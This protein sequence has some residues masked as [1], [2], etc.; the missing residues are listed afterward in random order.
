VSR[1]AD[2]VV[3]GDGPAGSALARAAANSGADTV[4]VGVDADWTATYSTWLDDLEPV[5]ALID[6]DAVI[7]RR[8]SAV[9]THAAE[10]QQIARAYGV[11]DNRALRDRLRDGVDHVVAEVTSVEPG[12]EPVVVVRGGERLRTRLVVDATGWPATFAGRGSLGRAV[13]RARSAPA[14][15]TAIGVVLPDAPDGDLGRPTFMDFRMPVAGDRVSTVG[16]AGVATFCYALPVHDGWL[17]E[18]T[19]LAARPAVEPVALLPRLAARLGRHPDD[20]LSSAV[21]TEYVRIPMGGARPEPDRPIVAFG[22]AAGFVHPATGFSLAASLRAAPRVGRALADAVAGPGPADA[23]AV[24][25]SVWPAPQRRTRV[26]HD[27]GLEVLLDLEPE[28]VGEFFGCFFALPMEQWR[29]Y[30]RIDASPAE[31]AEVMAKVFRSA[32]WP[33]RRRLMSSN[34]L[35]FARLVRP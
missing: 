28:R 8:C 17:V 13:G 24:A 19:V 2:V 35:A 34:P 32:P 11:V 12:P 20:L 22:A 5:A 7:G 6:V 31:V 4:L 29:P 33:L 9:W 26:L 14:W 18:E 1:S 30:L 23:D 15:Q 21:R 10:P 16:P 27:Y 25:D 3:I